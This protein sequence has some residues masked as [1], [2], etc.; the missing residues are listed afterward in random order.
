MKGDNSG[1]FLEFERQLVAVCGTDCKQKCMKIMF[2]M[3]GGLRVTIPDLDELY[4][5]DRNRS[6]RDEFRGN[7]YEELAI[8]YR[9]NTRQVRNIVSRG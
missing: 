6:I 3:L 5:R 8:K 7:N 1:D 9:L 4:R 2:A